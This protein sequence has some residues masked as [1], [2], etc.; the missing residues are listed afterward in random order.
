M[1]FL[2]ITRMQRTQK[3]RSKML[4]I[5]MCP[6]VRF[7]RGYD[8]LLASDVGSQ[9]HNLILRGTYIYNVSYNKKYEQKAKKNVW[10]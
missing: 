10:I 3:I 6:Y 7:K 8:G 4:V 5:N 9:F 2:A 1:I